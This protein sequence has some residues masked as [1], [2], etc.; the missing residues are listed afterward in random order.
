MY[1]DKAMAKLLLS[2]PGSP[3]ES[4]TN[5]HDIQDSPYWKSLYSNN[6]LFKEDKHGI[7]LAFCT[8]GVNPFSHLQVNFVFN[9]ANHDDHA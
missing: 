5:V 6:G 9:V 1:K 3:L 8:D 2:H 4:F 7:S